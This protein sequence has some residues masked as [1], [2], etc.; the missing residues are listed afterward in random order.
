MSDRRPDGV[1]GA[2]GAGGVEG[3]E[4]LGSRVN[5]LSAD[6]VGDR[7]QRWQMHDVDAAGALDDRPPAAFS[8]TLRL[9]NGVVKKGVARKQLLPPPQ[10]Q[11]PGRSYEQGLKEGREQ[12]LEQGKK[13]GHQQ[14]WQS[15][16][17]AG[18]EAGHAEGLAQGLQAAREQAAQE[19]QQQAQRQEQAEVNERVA[20]LDALLGAAEQS[21]S[22][23][24]NQLQTQLAQGL[25]DLA[26]GIARQVV[27]TTLQANPA[28]LLET[29][30][31]V[32]H[33]QPGQAQDA[34][35]RLYVHP[36]DEQL[37]APFL[38]TLPN[39][40]RWQIITDKSITPGGCVLHTALGQVDATLQTRWQRMAQSLEYSLAQSA[41]QPLSSPQLALQQTAQA[42]GK[43]A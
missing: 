28:A 12:G 26:L 14:G 31:Q 29:I 35:L 40:P 37:V 19:A 18:L 10:K 39:R 34:A 4:R 21:L 41:L 16:F 43:E 30:K 22:Q 38:Q 9:V 5:C 2:G 32:L 24:G 8:T 25:L 1:G 3:A 17:E 6:S 11:T 15:G 42:Q 7:W 36:D 13:Q 23:L 33:V 27:Q 20:R